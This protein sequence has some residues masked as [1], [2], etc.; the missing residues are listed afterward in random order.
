MQHLVE[1][2][3]LPPEIEG[4]V[5]G[6][7]TLQIGAL[8][9]LANPS[10]V[11]FK[12]VFYGEE[13]SG[14]ILSSG[15][16]KGVPQRIKYTL[17]CPQ[18][19]FANYLTDMK[20]LQIEVLDS[21]RNQLI[22]LVKIQ[23]TL[24][25]RRD[26]RS[27]IGKLAANPM[28]VNLEL[29]GV[30]PILSPRGDLK[31]GEVEIKAWTDFHI[32]RADIRESRA[33][34]ASFK[35]NEL[36][37][38]FDELPKKPAD[39][40]VKTAERAAESR[41]EYK[42]AK[43]EPV[44]TV[45]RSL[46][47]RVD[48]PKAITEVAEPSPLP[49]APTKVDDQ[50][51]P[52]NKDRWDALKE[53]GLKLKQRMEAVVET[54]DVKAEE[55]PVHATVK[56]TKKFKPEHRKGPSKAK[57]DEP[58][59]VIER[60]GHDKPKDVGEKSKAG[61]VKPRGP[62]KPRDVAQRPQVEAFKP[63][64][65][66]KMPEEPSKMQ[67]MHYK[68]P[69]E[70]PEELRR[71]TRELQKLLV[72]INTLT[73]L[74]PISP[75]VIEVSLPLPYKEEGDR[76]VQV[77]TD[78]F[79]LHHKGGA[80]S[81]YRFNH[82][83][84]HDI[85]FGEGF[86]A[87]LAN[88]PIR[89][90]LLSAGTPKAK[91][92]ELSKA[93]VLWE[94]LL[95]SPN[96][97][98]TTV[99]E[100][101]GEDPLLGKAT[102]ARLEATF[103][104]GK[105]GLRSPE[106]QTHVV[107]VAAKTFLLYLNI[108][109]A[110]QLAQRDDGSRRN[111][112]L[113]YKTFPDREQIC[114]PVLWN[115]VDGAP[116]RHTSI[117]PVSEAVAERLASALL[118][119]EVWDK[120]ASNRDELIGL[121][122]LPLSM[123]ATALGSGADFFASSVYPMTAF[124]DGRPIHNFKTPEA[125]GYLRVCLAM[126]SSAQVRRLQDSREPQDS[127]EPKVQSKQAAVQMSPP[128][129]HTEA[130][131]QTSTDR[132]AEPEDRQDTQSRRKADLGKVFES[133][134]SI[135]DLAAFLNRKDLREEVVQTDL[136]H[137]PAL[138]EK[139]PSKLVNEPPRSTSPDLLLHQD[140][141]VLNRSVDVPEEFDE[142]LAAVKAF[143]LDKIEEFDA[144]FRALQTE[145]N[146][147]ILKVLDAGVA[148]GLAE[149]RWN[150]VLEAFLEE[151]L[152]SS[153]YDVKLTELRDFLQLPVL[154]LRSIQHSFSIRVPELL[155]CPMLQREANCFLKLVLPVDEASIESE[156]L[157]PR[158]RNLPLKIKA[159]LS[160]IGEAGRPLAELLNCEGVVLQLLQ[161]TEN[162]TVVLGH[163]LLPV[164]ELTE[165]SEGASLSRVLCIYASRNT[166]GQEVL[167]KVR[168][169]VDYTS[170]EVWRPDVSESSEL[171]YS[172]QTCIERSIPR[173]C[174]VTV[175]IEGCADLAKAA[176]HFQAEGLRLSQGKCI[177]RVNL[178]KEADNSDAVVETA[179]M[180]FSDVMA[181]RTTNC[182]EITFNEDVLRYFEAKAADVEVVW[183]GDLL[184]GAAKVPL[185]GL[186]LNGSIAG[187]FPLLGEFGQYRG[188]VAL[189]LT[190]SKEEPY[191]SKRVAESVVDRRHSQEKPLPDKD[192]LESQK[193]VPDIHK[194][195]PN[196][197]IVI[198]T[199]LNLPKPTSGE[200]LNAYVIILWRQQRFS[201]APILRSSY[202][203]WHASFDVIVNP[204]QF[205]SSE[206][207]LQVWHKSYTGHDQELGQCCVSLAP[208]A[209]VPEIDGWYHVQTPSGY[210]GQVKVKVVPH[211]PLVI[212]RP[213]A[214]MPVL[215]SP[216]K[217][218]RTLAAFESKL[219]TISGELSQDKDLHAKLRNHMQDLED[220][221]R[222]W[223]AKH[224][225]HRS[226]RDTQ[227]SAPVRE[228]RVL[229][230]AAWHPSSSPSIRSASPVAIET[231]LAR[232]YDSPTRS[233]YGAHTTVK[234]LHT[235]ANHHSFNLDTLLPTSEPRRNPFPYK[236]DE[237]IRPMQAITHAAD[238]YK[239]PQERTPSRQRRP[240]SQMAAAEVSRIAA[241]MKSG[242]K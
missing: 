180:G 73:L 134:E 200:A 67:Q 225:P 153:S 105:D 65:I 63:Q 51:P 119:I 82:S 194:E 13:A 49:I 68:E 148:L 80:D 142:V 158:T 86:Y 231:G 17:R 44:I 23:L 133:L 27:A 70:T 152:E 233:A 111:L 204:G 230:P 235:D 206:V 15:D 69:L 8:S 241:I 229:S 226:P 212:R 112:F 34:V 146:V 164:E 5:Y 3:S 11:V 192:T 75:P 53:R 189:A 122:K 155:H 205:A 21:S 130:M 126:G 40:A 151:S 147:T 168:L 41:R 43:A 209:R 150:R 4:Q 47:K 216:Q 25:L 7:L 160:C 118:I 54:E 101:I 106:P 187:E 103:S 26:N 66:S 31:I 202:P 183:E 220:L 52:R 102:I 98:Y 167:G 56:A 128:R 135:S 16:V 93:E 137:L 71:D 39:R 236:A 22:G 178:F 170:K 165:L 62:D 213:L 36:K 159:E 208:L 20:V 161:K 61:V 79:K 33:S 232:S 108:D 129:S 114:T 177:A 88:L 203:A 99:L 157:P 185:V 123:F 169:I 214:E 81:V 207:Q 143:A 2:P 199:A 240:Q 215:Q 234:F 184:I 193:K 211:V 217:K 78:S 116:I 196:L 132:F 131:V 85:A 162:T 239:S 97:T 92:A 140:Q 46:L 156:Y 110:F 18:T 197:Q 242:S 188:C 218:S 224:E 6:L 172:K 222:T 138:T 173:E 121:V 76:Q 181:F 35:L 174:Y 221:K 96:Y 42:A 89:I 87:K 90:R 91:V 182:L 45:P 107:S 12:V 84:L 191:L 219:L 38:E 9:W 227:S 58:P 166:R 228:N 1:L 19:N 50:E 32:S 48:V 124:D 113:T 223:S 139:S 74:S 117:M 109:H 237:I 14:H 72:Q 141:R 28:L 100:F 37:A 238:R 127:V 83:S 60:P 30:F 94:K 77:L 10:T 115:Y 210:C 136:P 24:Y 120:L 59:K 29:E 144:S 149:A 125:A 64:E 104:L 95:V 198:E 154:S 145:G 175:T 176:K 186:L 195:N 163:A 57:L 55:T 190:L 171:I 179:S 201:T